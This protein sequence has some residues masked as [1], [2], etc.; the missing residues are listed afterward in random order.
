MADKR[1]LYHPKMKIM[2]IIKALTT[3]FRNKVMISLITTAT[4]IELIIYLTI[5]FK[6]T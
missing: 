6:A 3:E 5:H 1:K 4:E 2:K